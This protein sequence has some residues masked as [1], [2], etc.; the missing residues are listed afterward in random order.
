MSIPRVV[1]SPASLNEIS[2]FLPAACPSAPLDRL[3][4]HARLPL[5][6]IA[7][8]ERRPVTPIATRS[9]RKYY[10][11]SSLSFR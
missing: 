9:S 4:R 2:V 1:Y 7:P 10:F 6:M 11:T 3:D 5:A 8:G